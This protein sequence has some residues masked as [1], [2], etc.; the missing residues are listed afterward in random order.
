MELCIFDFLK[1][2]FYK[3]FEKN[4]GWGL[5]YNESKFVNGYYYSNV[6]KIV[7]LW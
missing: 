6:M 5:N 2:K 4:E 7:C 1:I 3:L